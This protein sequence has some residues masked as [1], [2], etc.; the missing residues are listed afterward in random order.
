MT[1]G[2]LVLMLQLHVLRQMHQVGEDLMAEGARNQLRGAA[3][4]VVTRYMQL[5]VG[6][7]GREERREQAK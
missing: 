3:V 5:D 6:D 2:G 1:V 4:R 7:A